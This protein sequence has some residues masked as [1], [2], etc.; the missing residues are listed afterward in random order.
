MVLFFSVFDFKFCLGFWGVLV[1]SKYSFWGCGRTLFNYVGASFNLNVTCTYL[2]FIIF[3]LVSLSS[4]S[5]GAPFFDELLKAANKTQKLVSPQ[6]NGK[7]TE[8]LKLTS[9]PS[10]EKVVTETTQVA[11][12]DNV[13]RDVKKKRTPKK[14]LYGREVFLRNHHVVT[15]LAGGLASTDARMASDISNVLDQDGGDIPIRVVPLLGR[16]GIQNV[17]DLLFM[18]GVDMAIV[19]QGQLGFLE[20][21][22]PVFYKDIRQNVQ[23]ITKLYNSEMQI[24]SHRSVGSLLELSGKRVVL[25][26][27]LGATDMDARYVFAQLGIDIEVVNVDFSNGL[28]QLENNGVDAIVAFGGAPIEGFK[29]LRDPSKFHFLSITP[30][31]VG[32]NQ[33]FKITDEYLPIK[34]TAKQYPNLIAKNK[35]VSTISS[36]VVLAIYK[37]K[38]S[39]KRYKKLS[40]FVQA[41]FT[42]LYGFDQRSRHPKWQEINID[43]KVAG[44]S[45]FGAASEWLKNR[46]KEIGQEIS[47]GEMKIAMDAFVRQ[48]SK[49]GNSEQVTPLLR[50]D[51]WASMT[52]V[53][54]RYWAIGQ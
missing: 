52:R 53:F 45:Q 3:S 25:G 21:Q 47:A 13:R 9:P 37:W 8:K 14:S 18:K 7:P 11:Q 16:G 36:S 41:F 26:K 51:I 30:Q 50:D 48:Y 20:L 54:G 29:A 38:R 42:N 17:K 1:L 31:T 6:V 2:S 27:K 35:P 46:Q 34:L 44:W 10:S 4:L 43:A 28:D 24:L 19:S 49:I 5:H 33:Y 23:Y 39:H 15:L 40:R 22:D 12:S 32:L